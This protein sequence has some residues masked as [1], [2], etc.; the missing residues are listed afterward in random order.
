MFS[1]L[2]KNN[3]VEQQANT[4]TSGIAESALHSLHDSIQELAQKGAFINFL[5]RKDDI[6]KVLRPLAQAQRNCKL[7]MLDSIVSIWVEQTRPLLTIA[8]MFRDMRELGN[9]SQ[10]MASASEEMLASINEVGRSAEIV[11]RD[12]Q[13]VKTELTSSV[14]LFC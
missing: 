4:A 11:S 10:T 7:G 6:A 5:T 3:T 14:C 8:E 9:R 12:A 1:F 13:D 2:H